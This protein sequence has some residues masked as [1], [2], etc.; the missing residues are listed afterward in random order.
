MNANERQTLEHKIADLVRRILAIGS[1]ENIDRRLMAERDL[2]IELVDTYADLV[3]LF[4][5]P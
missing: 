3:A 2:L 1:I 5:Q 4:Q